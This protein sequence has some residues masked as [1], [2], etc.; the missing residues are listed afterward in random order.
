MSFNCIL[1]PSWTTN[2]KL[3]RLAFLLGKVVIEYSQC[4][5]KKAYISQLERRP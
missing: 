3:R 1:L 5:A 4:L 2:L